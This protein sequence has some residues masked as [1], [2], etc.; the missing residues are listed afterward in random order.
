MTMMSSSAQT[1]GSFTPLRV[2]VMGC[3]RG[4][5]TLMQRLV[6]DRLGLSTLP[7]TRFFANMAGNVETHMF[8]RT[9]RAMP[10]H[11]QISSQ[12][13]EALGRSTGMRLLDI[14]GVPA[15]EGRKWASFR[16]TTAGFLALMD[17]LAKAEA[18]AG[19]LEKTPFH[20][21]Y[22]PLI[23]RLVPGA[24]MIHILRDAQETVGSIRDAAN[25]YHDP[26][27][28]NYDRVERDVDNWNA[29]TAASA[30]M[31]GRPQQIFVPYAAL[32]RAPEAVMDRVAEMMGSTAQAGGGLRQPAG[33]TSSRDQQWKQAAVNG[34]VAPSVSKWST[35]LTPEQQSRAQ[36]LIEPVPA[37]LQQAM[38]PFFALAG[39]REGENI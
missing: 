35:A 34:A 20:V 28:I 24:W 22:A 10:L 21:L 30:A 14:P 12:L 11:R 4:G 27:A 32:T 18:T 17:G 5:T 16:S 1:A 29:S 31:V 3:S 39:L 2:F 37:A 26:W 19:W 25:N 6:A 8:P 33:L 13:R 9:A 38:A 7:E 23:A 36:A 15:I